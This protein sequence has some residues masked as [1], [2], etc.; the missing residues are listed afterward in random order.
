MYVT[1]MYLFEVFRWKIEYFYRSFILRFVRIFYCCSYYVY[2]VVPKL[3]SIVKFRR[4]LIV[5]FF[6]FRLCAM[7]FDELMCICSILNSECEENAKP[8]FENDLCYVQD[9]LPVW[10]IFGLLDFRSR[11]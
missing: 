8:Q 5:F 6:F 1:L 4:S 9:L 10:N 3:Y 11:L 2:D 7:T